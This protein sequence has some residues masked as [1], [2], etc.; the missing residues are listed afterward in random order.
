MDYCTQCGKKVRENE[1]RCVC[2]FK[3]DENGKSTSIMKN[4]KEMIIPILVGF[5]L[6]SSIYST[7]KISELEGK[8]NKLLYHSHDTQTPFSDSFPK[9]DSDYIY[10]LKSDFDLRLRMLENDPDRR[11]RS[12]LLKQGFYQMVDDMEKMK[13]QI[14]RI[15]S[16]LDY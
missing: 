15:E 4:I 5:T 10:D 9:I 14:R 12:N 2:G 11:F 16:E 1:D 7:I 3:Y 13:K 6:V 8:Q